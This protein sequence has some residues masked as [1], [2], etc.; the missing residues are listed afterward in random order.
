L[1]DG[2][3]GRLSRVQ[4]QPYTLAGEGVYIAGSIADKQYSPVGLT[5]YTL[6]ERPGTSR[7]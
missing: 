4:A 6:L 3:D 5:G 7:F 2:I 1:A